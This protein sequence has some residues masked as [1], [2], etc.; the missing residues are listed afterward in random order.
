M[1]N[2]AVCTDH[3]AHL[4]LKISARQ[5]IRS[6]EFR[7][8]QYIYSNSSLRYDGTDLTNEFLGFNLYRYFAF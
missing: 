6:A 3:K 2:A 5:H 1:R 8:N 7:N 4:F